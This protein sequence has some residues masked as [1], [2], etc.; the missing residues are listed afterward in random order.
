VCICSLVTATFIA[1]SLLF[2][3]AFEK[4][5]SST[6]CRYI[7]EDQLFVRYSTRKATKYLKCTFEDCTARAI[8]KNDQFTLK[9]V[10]TEHETAT[11]AIISQMRIRAECRKRAVEGDTNTLRHLFDEVCKPLQLFYIKCNKNHS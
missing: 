5:Q 9:T 2:Q 8:I 4:V 1:A 7:V 6:G 10:H 3:M 11:L